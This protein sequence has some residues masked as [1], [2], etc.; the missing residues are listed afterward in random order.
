MKNNIRWGTLAVCVIICQLAGIIGAFFTQQSVTTWFLTLRKPVFN[1]PAWVF[2]PMWTLLYLL[3][4][5]ALYQVVTRARYRENKCVYTIFS[6]Q[7]ILNSLWSFFFFG[8]RSP[9]LALIDIVLL[10]IAVGYT[11][12]ELYR[13][14]PSA[15]FIMI[16]YQL[17]IL[18]ATVLNLA[19]YLLN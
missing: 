11:L 12:I 14:K 17:W 13:V 4:G 2:G 19:I 6:I 10:D 18:F 15:A 8:M 3:M 9:G 5:I 1:P 16:P 7:L